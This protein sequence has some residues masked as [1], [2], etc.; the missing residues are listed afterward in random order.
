MQRPISRALQ[1]D[2]LIMENKQQHIYTD[3]MHID[4]DKFLVIITDPL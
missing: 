4:A 2:S 3:V 1:E